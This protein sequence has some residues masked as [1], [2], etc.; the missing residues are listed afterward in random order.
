MATETVLTADGDENA[1]SFQSVKDRSIC[2][3]DNHFAREMIA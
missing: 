1:R 3:N 2:N